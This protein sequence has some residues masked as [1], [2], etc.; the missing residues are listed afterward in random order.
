MKPHSDPEAYY[1]HLSRLMITTVIIVSL[2]PML[3]VGGVIY[4]QFHFSYKEK[5]YAHLGELIRK[6]KQ[7]IDAFLKEKLGDIRFLASTCGIDDLTR[8][9]VLEERLDGLREEYGTI[10]EDLGVVDAQGRQ[11]AYAGPFKLDD[12][13]YGEA[14]WF[15]KAIGSPHFISDVFMGLRGYPHF[16]V[17]A[18]YTVDG[19]PWLLRA[20]INFTAFNS[21]VENIRIEEMGGRGGKSLFVGAFLKDDDWLMVYQ[22]KSSDAFSDLHQA[23]GLAIL[24]AFLGALGIVSTATIYTRQMIGRIS[25]ADRDKELMNK[26]VIE[27][28]K[29]A[30]IGQLAAGIAHEINNPVAIMVEEAGW[31]E[32]L[33][34]EEEFHEGKNLEEFQRALR[35]IN[36]QGRRCKEITHKLLSFARK[37]D[38]RAQ[39]VNVNELIRELVDLSSQRSRYSNVTI[40]TR[41]APNLPVL[42]ASQTEVQ[43]VLLNLINNALD[44][45]EK[46]GGTLDIATRREK[47]HLLIKVADSGPGIPAAN[48]EAPEGSGRSLPQ[49]Q[50]VSGRPGGADLAAPVRRRSRAVDFPLEWGTALFIFGGGISLGLAMGYSGAADYF[51]YL[52]FPLVQGGGWLL[53]FAGGGGPDPAHRHSHGPIGGGRPPGPGPLPRDGHFLR[54][55]LLKPADFEELLGKLEAARNRKVAQEERIRRAEAKLMVRRSGGLS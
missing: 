6:H 23:Q 1:R 42:E 10:F 38:S 35:Q 52:F 47:A 30:S 8:K 31:I 28:G 32:D 15:K 33:L 54:H 2:I 4:H 40:N 29:L 12:A 5:V 44:A 20:T 7:N 48:L 43:Q 26:Q 39:E 53:L 37:T 11:V 14:D 24:M 50:A 3:L 9:A 41:L 51:A 18:R 19:S 25:E 22:Q 16:I 34:E 17:A 36:T 21:L 49:G 45:M 27:T 55:Y 13:D 46:E